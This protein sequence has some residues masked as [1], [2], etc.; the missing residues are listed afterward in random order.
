MNSF[1]VDTCGDN[2]DRSY[3]CAGKVVVKKRG[4][5]LEANGYVEK[6]DKN[7]FSVVLENEETVKVEKPQFNKESGRWLYLSRESDRYDT[8]Q[9]DPVRIKILEKGNI[10]FLFQK[11][12]VKI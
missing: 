12:K 4:T 7:R 6:E 11:I 3:G 1:L 2:E 5:R 9:Y 8:I 10:H